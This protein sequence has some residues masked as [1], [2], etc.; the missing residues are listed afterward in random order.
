[1]RITKASE[2]CIELIKRFE[3]LKLQAYKCPAGIWTIGFGSTYYEDGTRIKQ[4]EVITDYRA[5]QLLQRTL[6][7]YEQGVD[8]NT[9]DDI[10][11]NQFD[12]LVDFAYNLGVQNLKISQL[13]KKVNAN[14]SDLSIRS[15]F[16]KWA[17]AGGV[18]LKGLVARRAAEADLYF[19]IENP[20][21]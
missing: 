1:M 6:I 10:N 14:P 4:G 11:Q 16:G 17:K 18:V 21:V 19:K 8:S 7:Q 13:L 5:K 15:E 12:A 3:G 9:R 2:N 20:L